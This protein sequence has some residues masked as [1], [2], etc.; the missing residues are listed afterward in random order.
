MGEPGLTSP[1]RRRGLPPLSEAVGLIWH[2]V[3]REC[4]SPP[5]RDRLPIAPPPPEQVSSRSTLG[6]LC[7]VDRWYLAL[8]KQAKRTSRPCQRWSAPLI[9]GEG[10]LAP[11]PRPICGKDN[12]GR[13]IQR[14]K[15]VH[16]VSVPSGGVSPSVHRC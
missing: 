8:Q 1:R 2:V 5:R 14:Q 3:T 10:V 6:G 11:E 4:L 15:V 13:R 16:T 9:R 7:P 12:T